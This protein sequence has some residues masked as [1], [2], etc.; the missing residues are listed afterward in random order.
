MWS[1]GNKFFS[2][3][4]INQMS[5]FLINIHNWYSLQLL[6]TWLFLLLQTLRLSKNEW[7][8]S[9]TFDRGIFLIDTT[10]RSLTLLFPFSYCCHVP[11]L[12]CVTLLT[13]V[14]RYQGNQYQYLWH[15]SAVIYWSSSNDH[16]IKVVM[17]ARGSV[18][19]ILLYVCSNL[20]LCLQM[21][22]LTK[23]TMKQQVLFV[24][25]Q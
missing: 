18:L 6:L 22:S 15:I 5:N 2:G 19:Y 7:Y 20:H 11:K 25:L 9:S 1:T 3:I 14:G 10:F 21:H 12:I 24:Q 13:K 17:K 8:V 4:W 16:L 23:K